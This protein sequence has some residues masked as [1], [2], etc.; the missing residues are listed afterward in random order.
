[1]FVFDREWREKLQR[2]KTCLWVS[3]ISGCPSIANLPVESERQRLGR[4]YHH[5]SFIHNKH[6]SFVTW[7]V[8]PDPTVCSRVFPMLSAGL[9]YS[10]SSGYTFP[11][12]LMH[13][14]IK[15]SNFTPKD[16]TVHIVCLLSIHASNSCSD[17]SGLQ[18]LFWNEKVG[19]S[20]IRSFWI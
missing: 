14:L 5:I 9:F 19:K 7:L 15:T 12:L 20:A 1:M 17:I 18:S 13:M 3:W 10:G 16:N 2:T 4:W 8:F 6:L 11:N